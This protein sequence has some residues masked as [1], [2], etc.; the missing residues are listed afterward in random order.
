MD[1][2]GYDLG[3]SAD[4]R[5]LK[6]QNTLQKS[7]GRKHTPLALGRLHPLQLY[8]ANQFPLPDRIA[9]CALLAAIDPDNVSQTS[10]AVETESADLL[11]HR[12]HLEKV[13]LR[14][15]SIASVAPV[16]SETAPASIHKYDSQ[17]VRI[18]LPGFPATVPAANTN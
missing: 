1:F 12:S 8:S 14:L 5:C 13:L 7:C 9:F 6:Q 16:S 17:T 10:H 4:H 3:K 2:W 18:T 11:R 15:D